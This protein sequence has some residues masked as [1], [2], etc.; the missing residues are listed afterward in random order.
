MLNR[1]GRSIE[2]AKGKEYRHHR[3]DLAH[4]IAGYGE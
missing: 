3:P 4:T 2:T 1:V